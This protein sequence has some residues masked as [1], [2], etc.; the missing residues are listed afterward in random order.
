MQES[1]KEETPDVLE[2]LKKK[3]RIKKIS[4]IAIISVLIIIIVFLVFSFYAYFQSPERTLGLGANI[5]SALL[6]EDGKI[7]YLKL[8]GGSLDKNITKIKFIFTDEQGNEHIYE[9]TEGA[10]EIEVPF[11][12]SFWDWLFG[13]Q[14]IGS[15]DYEINS[16]N[17]G[18]SD[19][20]NINEVGVLFEYKTETGE[21]IETPVLDTGKTTT[22]TTTGE[23]SPGP[24]DSGTTT[25]TP[26]PSCTDDAGCSA[27]GSF[28]QGSMPFN[29]S[30]NISD[31]CLD[32]INRS[33]CGSGYYCSGGS[34][35]LISGNTYLTNEDTPIN[36]TLSSSI[37]GNW[38]RIT[39]PGHG[40]TQNK[41]SLANVNTI[42]LTYAP[43]LNYNGQDYFIYSVS[44][45]INLEII[46]VNITINP[47][48]DPPTFVIRDWSVLAGT[49]MTFTLPKT[50]VDGD[51]ISYSIKN[52]NLPGNV[53]VFNE[54]VF[55]WNAQQGLNDGEYT[56][57]IEANDSKREP[58]SLYQKAITVTVNDAPATYYLNVSVSSSGNGLSWITAFKNIT[59][60]QAI[61]QAGDTVLIANGDYG[62]FGD[63]YTAR[64][65]WVTWRG[66]GEKPVFNSITIYNPDRYIIFNNINVSGTGKT[67]AGD[68]WA[69]IDLDYRA[70]N[71]K[72]LN[73]HVEDLNQTIE[74]NGSLFTYA[75]RTVNVDDVEI[76]NTTV[77]GSRYGVQLFGDNL[78]FK[79]NIVRYQ[80]GDCI[81]AVS[82]SNSVID[83]NYIY[84]GFDYLGTGEHIDGIQFF[85]VGPA[86]SYIQPKNVV[87]TN[88]KMFNLTG[89][90]IFVQANWIDCL[91]YIYNITI[92]NNTLGRQSVDD[93][94]LPVQLQG[95][96]NFI[97]EHNTIY[98]KVGVRGGSKGI[99]KNNIIGYLIYDGAN[100]TIDYEGYNL[101][102]QFLSNDPLLPLPNKSNSIIETPVYF[103][104]SSFDYR[105][106]PQS[107]ACTMSST[108]DYVGALPCVGCTDDNP[109]AVFT[110]DQDDNYDPQIIFSASKSLACSDS[111]INYEWDFGDG[112]KGSGMTIEHNF[113]PGYFK[114]NLTVTNN[115]GKTN[116]QIREISV[117]PVAEPNLLVYL[118]FDDNVQDFSG[119]GIHGEWAGNPPTPLY[120][121]GI[122]NNA[123]LFGG[124]D[125]S[126]VNLNDLQGMAELTIS[127][128]AKKNKANS[129]GF[130][131]NKHVYYQMTVGKSSFGFA[132]GND[133]N[134]MYG[135][136][137]S[138]SKID[139]TDWHHYSIAYNGSIVK[140]YI[141]GVEMKNYS[142]ITGNIRSSGYW[143]LKIGRSSVGT[144]PSFDGV[145]DEF[146]MY[147]RALNESEIAQMYCRQG[148]DTLNPTFCAG[149]PSLSPFTQLLNWIKGLLTQETGNAILTGKAILTGNAVNETNENGES[150]VPYII[151][152]LLAGIILIIVIIIVKIKKNKKKSGKKIG[153]R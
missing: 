14:F 147:D 32:R 4:I 6:S 11:K 88:N 18:L 105:P 58:N 78:T 143:D 136:G 148:G 130:L 134:Y 75:I 129:S 116:S 37:T 9:T 132:V 30:L 142:G 77:I 65:A 74:T 76:V 50:D 13:R 15:Y 101:I 96:K 124:I 84:N 10:K 27:V 79:D 17:A 106:L 59:N 72:I 70:S 117:L 110:I 63:M 7:S 127:L 21:T 64:T 44:D 38:T 67:S 145:I 82:I 104:I 47:I 126:S 118:N 12:K 109:V 2:T 52:H 137:V 81:R 103:D 31:R 91:G 40:T 121:A 43:S 151:L 48:N 5:E 42:N 71:V 123:A 108:N 23:G 69:S 113:E 153:R 57:T 152:S 36:I 128:W 8:A 111:I 94:A 86:C 140:A 99:L 41:T 45:G 107:T 3:N 125:N 62:R 35:Q 112:T 83:N 54:N 55:S 49:S 92:I 102:G 66:I 119:R 16:E 131:M 26:T 24:S 89:Q 141:D 93:A 22:I 1:E 114:V 19:F 90:M 97:F 133:T 46:R 80:W 138:T 29:C 100:I 73:S 146:K 28:C 60:A 20:N 61:V 120:T 25:P 39:S 144:E 135:V 68:T 85:P 122:K 53:P 87:V 33:E 139:N 149:V 34:C 150:K 56:L 98:G 95:V 115:I 51:V